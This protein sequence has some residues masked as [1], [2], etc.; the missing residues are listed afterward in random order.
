MGGPTT[1]AGLS[2]ALEADQSGVGG[3]PYGHWGFR[4]KPQPL[5]GNILREPSPWWQETGDHLLTRT[6]GPWLVSLPS[7]PPD[8]APVVAGGGICE[9]G[10]EDGVLARVP[11]EDTPTREC[12]WPGWPRIPRRM[13]GRVGAAH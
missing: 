13:G 2:R 3:P 9:G 7:G 8:L 1:R 6:V 4:S 11:A 10:G 12:L 5:A